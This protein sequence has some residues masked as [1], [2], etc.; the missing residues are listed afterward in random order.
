MQNKLVLGSDFDENVRFFD[1]KIRYGESFDII[2]RKLMISGTRSV[3]YYIDGFIK[4]EQ[5]QKFLTFLM[6]QKD[7]GEGKKGDAERFSA[8][9]PAVE[10]DAECDVENIVT[11]VMSGCTAFFCE[12]FGP[13]CLVRPDYSPKKKSSAGTAK[14]EKAPAAPAPKKPQ[15]KKGWAKAKPKKN[16][17]PNSSKKKG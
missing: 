3:M 10:V 11:A 7:F 8:V 6:S 4:A 2:K 1:E 12:G 13:D 15:S 17:K 5:M 9:I 14:A 16:A